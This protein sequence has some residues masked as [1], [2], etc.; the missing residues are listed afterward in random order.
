MGQNNENPFV[1]YLKTQLNENKLGILNQ[2]ENYMIEIDLENQ[3]KIN[4]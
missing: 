3:N 1:Q 2:N 4:P